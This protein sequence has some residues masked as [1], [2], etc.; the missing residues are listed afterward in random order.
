MKLLIR[1]ALIVTQNEGRE[2]KQGNILVEEGII[3]E[4]SEKKPEANVDFEISGRFAVVPG[5]INLHTHVAMTLFR[6]LVDDLTLEKFLEVTFTLD[7]KRKNDD[8]YAGAL[9][10][11]VEMLHSGITTFVDFYYSEDVIASALEKTGMRGILAWTT[12]DEKY[13]TQKGKPLSNA[14]NFIRNFASRP[15]LKPAIAVQGVYV[16]SDETWLKA[17]EISEKYSTICTYHLAETKKE[18]YEFIN[19]KNERPCEHLEKIGFLGSN[20]IAVHS[21]YLL[22]REINALA[23]HG[24]SVAHCPVSNMKLASGIAPVPEMLDALINVG[25]G[26]DSAAS[27]NAL[28]LLREVH[29]AGLLHKVVLGDP[30]LLNAQTLLD[31]L[32]INGA[33]AVG[34]EKE[35]GSIE[36]GKK[37]DLVVFNLKHPSI[38]PAS[39]QNI[40]SNIVYSA[41]PDAIEYVLV[42]GRP[43]IAGGKYQEIDEIVEL[44]ENARKK[45]C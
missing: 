27:N 34:M 21:C 37:G 3:K 29:I 10:G 16:A 17:K 18:V 30:S 31:M 24:V 39:K 6:G 42:E 5:F 43:R 25:L 9:L 35:I 26:T 7:A 4:I 15:L 1:D 38:A 14:E 2:I 44:A 8:I 36:E 22:R 28:N 13:T 32:T 12:L 23:R 19:Q 40:V 33:E 41:N 20:Q 11:M 45:F